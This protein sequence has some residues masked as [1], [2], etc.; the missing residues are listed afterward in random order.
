MKIVFYKD[1]ISRKYESRMR[2]E[3]E[4]LAEVL[5]PKRWQHSR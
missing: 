5:E 4:C 3:A 1:E 2:L